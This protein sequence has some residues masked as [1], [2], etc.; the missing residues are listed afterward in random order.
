VYQ[1][2]MGATEEF[3]PPRLSSAPEARN[4]LCLLNGEHVRGGINCLLAKTACRFLPPEL[5]K[6][7][8]MAQMQPYNFLPHNKFLPLLG[9]KSL[10][11]VRRQQQHGGSAAAAAQ[12]RRSDGSMAAV[13][14]RW[15]L[16]SGSSLAAAAWRW[17]CGGGSLAM[18]A[19]WQCGG[20]GTAAAAWQWHGNGS[21]LMVAA[22]A[23]RRQWQ[24][25]CGGGGAA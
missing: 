10:A 15:Q 2:K 18:A 8:K 9:Q 14:Q 24:R 7:P 12:R 3:L 5:Q 25:G 22:S 21:S 20:S 11:A 6:N 16:G 19:L 13:R 1:C 23:Q 17:Q 4:L